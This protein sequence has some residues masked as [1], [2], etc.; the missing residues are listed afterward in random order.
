MFNTE[1]NRENPKKYWRSMNSLLN[2]TGN[3]DSIKEIVVENGR[4]M[5]GMEA[6]KI[7]NC[8]LSNIGSDLARN[9]TQ[10]PR[11]SPL[12]ALDV[13]LNGVFLFS[14]RK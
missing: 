11:N 10:P 14:S 4:K 8:Y 6:A 3:K 13:N 5:T 1:Q 12:R 9:I 7:L 2:K